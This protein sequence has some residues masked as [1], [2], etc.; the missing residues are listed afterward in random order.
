MT[1][2]PFAK[3][4]HDAMEY[5]SCSHSDHENSKSDYTSSASLEKQT[6]TYEI[7]SNIFK[8]IKSVIILGHLASVFKE[9]FFAVGVQL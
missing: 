6:L 7:Y 3:I 5:I 8:V 9:M 1:S 2:L 4:I